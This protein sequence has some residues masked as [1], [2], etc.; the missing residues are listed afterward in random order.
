M[1][2]C[3]FLKLHVT[4]AGLNEV[5]KLYVPSDKELRFHPCVK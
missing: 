1:N 2:G 5:V 4:L 3:V